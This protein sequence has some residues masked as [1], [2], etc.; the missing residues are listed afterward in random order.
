MSQLPNELIRY[1]NDAP[2]Q[3]RNL[4]RDATDD[5]LYDL[6]DRN[7]ARRNIAWLIIHELWE[8]RELRGFTRY[9]PRTDREME[10]LLETALQITR[11]VPKHTEADLIHGFKTNRSEHRADRLYFDMYTR[12]QPNSKNPA[13]LNATL[14]GYIDHP[15]SEPYFM[16]RVFLPYEQTMYFTVAQTELAFALWQIV[17]D[18]AL[19]IR[20]IAPLAD[21]SSF[22]D[23]AE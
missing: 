15:L 6:L 22:Q 20:P 5:E 11:T 23:A 9:I 19:G 16:L 18:Q 1:L 17:A 10:S 4:I 3:L 2:A 13:A 12:I 21:P 7:A 8:V 14:T